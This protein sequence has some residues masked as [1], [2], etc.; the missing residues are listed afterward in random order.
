[1]SNS[2]IDT[3][4]VTEILNEL[5]NKASVLSQKIS[6]LKASSSGIRNCANKLNSYNGK[7]ITGS[8]TTIT[9]QM[10]SLA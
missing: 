7:R 9:K 4:K 5:Q 1:M 10:P 6:S 2:N 8:S 3:Q